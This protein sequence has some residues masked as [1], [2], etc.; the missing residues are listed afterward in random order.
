[1]PGL[2]ARAIYWENDGRRIYR[3]RIWGVV[4]KQFK[5]PQEV[6]NV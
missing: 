6:K 2:Y 4:G 5:I 3:C 1:M